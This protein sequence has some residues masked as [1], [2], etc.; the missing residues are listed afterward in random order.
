MV[1]HHPERGNPLWDPDAPREVDIFTVPDTAA[2]PEDHEPPHD[3]IVSA[4]RQISEEGGSHNFIVVLADPRRNLFV[5]FA[6]S[7]GSAT[8]LGE[9]VSDRFLTTPLSPEQR[10]RLRQLGWRQPTPRK[11]PN[12][13]RLW[14]VLNDADRRA[15]ADVALDT[16]ERVY[17]WPRGGSL[18]VTVHLDW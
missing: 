2:H 15:I 10:V 14:N 7:C 16:L 13:F 12:H 17:E 1:F 4:L 18:R 9:A 5:Q 11:R 8:I 6:T 3:R